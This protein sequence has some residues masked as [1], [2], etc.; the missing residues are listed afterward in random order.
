MEDDVDEVMGL[1]VRV[2]EE[3]ERE[4]QDW[5]RVVGIF[6]ASGCGRQD[7]L[8]KGLEVVEKLD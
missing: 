7:G 2:E 5:G 3:L 8:M 1:E 4:D 6:K